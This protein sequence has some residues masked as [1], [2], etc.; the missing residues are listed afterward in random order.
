MFVIYL[1][2]CGSIAAYLTYD[3]LKLDPHERFDGPGGAFGLI[4]ANLLA[5]GAGLGILVRVTDFFF[6]YKKIQKKFYWAL[7]LL[8]PV[9]LAGI[10]TAPSYYQKWQRRSPAEG[11]AY[12]AVNLLV[13]QTLMRVPTFSIISAALDDGNQPIKKMDMLHFI[14]NES[15]RKLCAMSR[16]GK[17]E[18]SVNSIT[19]NFSRVDVDKYYDRF[20]M[21]CEKDD[22]F[23]CKKERYFGVVPYIENLSLYYAE[24]YNADRM[25]GGTGDSLIKELNAG[26]SNDRYFNYTF[27][28]I[29]NTRDYNGGAVF[30]RCR[31]AR[32]N[33]FCQTNVT[34]S[35]DAR[36]TAGYVVSH[37]NTEADLHKLYKDSFEFLDK[38]KINGG[39]NGRPH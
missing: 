11:C 27:I 33:L 2:V 29:D 34:F 15:L 23:F 21:L 13:G 32:P 14:S 8:A 36:L 20:K 7:L 28:K 6:T 38:I 35:A 10:I 12:D 1:V 4:I 5:Y 26:I 31:E 24:H 25:F 22:Y 37:E 16:N 9:L 17:T 18:I 39:N 30:F 3:V 19:I